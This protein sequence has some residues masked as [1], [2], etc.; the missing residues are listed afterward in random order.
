MASREAK[1]SLLQKVFRCYIKVFY[2]PLFGLQF[3]NYSK[4]DFIFC[5]QINLDNT[6]CKYEY[7]FHWAKP[8]RR[9]KHHCLAH[10]FLL[11]NVSNLLEFTRS[12]SLKAKFISR[13][14]WKKYHSGYFDT[15]CKRTVVDGEVFSL[16]EGFLVINHLDFCSQTKILPD[17]SLL[18]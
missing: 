2:T 17:Q 12:S 10:I 16:K 7:L 15:F 3:V 4:K 9:L 6:N 14:N 18:C 1:D 8:F 5:M 13:S 11:V